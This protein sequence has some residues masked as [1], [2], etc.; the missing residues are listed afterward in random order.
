MIH[1]VNDSM[2]YGRGKAA[3]IGM[4]EEEYVDLFGPEFSV[5]TGDMRIDLI[6]EMNLPGL[7]R[8]LRDAVRWYLTMRE[9]LKN[10]LREIG[11]HEGTLAK[12]EAKLVA[13]TPADQYKA[14]SAAERKRKLDAIVHFDDQ[15]VLADALLEDAL[16]DKR[17]MS[18]EIEDATVVISSVGRRLQWRTS[19]TVGGVLAKTGKI[20]ADQ[21][22]EALSLA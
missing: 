14:G 11:Q 2:K 3:Q 20:T 15:W 19:Y 8:Q 10:T 21:V 13:T 5:Q 18:M 6:N 9:R 22:E 17:E 12:I 1:V 4:R 16:Q 7:D